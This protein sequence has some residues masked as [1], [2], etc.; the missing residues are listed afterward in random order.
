V[1]AG[2]APDWRDALARR[3]RGELVRDAPLAPRTSIRIGGP[4]DLLVRPADP[5]DVVA[6]LRAAR[7]LGVAV[8]VLGGGANTLVA[9]GGVRGVVL[10]LPRDLGGETPDPPRL[11]LPA[12]MPTARVVQRAHGLGLVG[13]E[14]L[15]GIPGTLGGAL[16]MNAGT[17]SGEMGD[18][19]THVE[20]ATADGVRE[21]T[22]GELGF[23]YR[24]CSLPEGAV[25]LRVGLRLRPG[26]V[27]EAARAM[28]VEWAQRERAQ[29]LDLPSFGSTFRNPPGDFAGRLVE[30]AGLKGERIG[31]AE[32]STRH[33]NFVVN[34]GGATAR[35]V[36]LLVRRMRDRVR[37]ELG[38]TL[39]TE[40]RLVGDFAAD[41]KLD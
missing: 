6:C 38:V 21:L 19:V 16:A 25:V 28:D 10:R 11:L 7:E 5:G 17:R 41:E 37:E 30:A 27:V 9:D 34:V 12:G 20:L 33:A 29:P 32:V 15:R 36:L 8:H 22:A 26:D 4:A 2:V 24:N 40:V 23:A 14:F 31:G 1:V 18:V 35:D 39:E 3:V 13:G